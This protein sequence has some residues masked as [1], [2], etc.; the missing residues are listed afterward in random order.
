M[1]W[2]TILSPI[3]GIVLTTFTAWMLNWLRKYL[4]AKYNVVI[5]DEDFAV[6]KRVVK[7]VEE[8]ALSGKL[9]LSTDRAIASAQKEAKAQSDLKEA[10]PEMDAASVVRKVDQAVAELPGIGSTG[11]LDCPKPGPMS[12]PGVSP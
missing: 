4:Q 9:L 11:K 2:M 5:S 10:R 12:E 3:I 7:A 8:K 1:D 6:A